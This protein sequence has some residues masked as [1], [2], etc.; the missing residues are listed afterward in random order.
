MIVFHPFQKSLDSH[1]I[2]RGGVEK[3][4]DDSIQLS[5]CNSGSTS[6]S[7][8]DNVLQHCFLTNKNEM[9]T[10]ITMGKEIAQIWA[11]Q[12]QPWALMGHPLS[13]GRVIT[14]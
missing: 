11:A 1:P 2:K 8:L 12:A 9:N 10:Q 6:S 14:R 5:L 4:S 7:T 3:N 13:L